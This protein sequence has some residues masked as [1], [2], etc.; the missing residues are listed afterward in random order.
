MHNGGK[1]GYTANGSGNF[2]WVVKQG[3]GW[4]QGHQFP[5]AR[6]TATKLFSL[7]PGAL[8]VSKCRAVGT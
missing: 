3:A 4:E 6:R 2:L 8:K 7:G 1:Q 5:L